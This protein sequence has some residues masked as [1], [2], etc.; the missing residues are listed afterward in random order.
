MKIA[1][2]LFVIL[3]LTAVNG[4][5]F[6]F[7]PAEVGHAQQTFIE[8]VSKPVAYGY[9]VRTS[10][11]DALPISLSED[12]V[13]GG[14]GYKVK[15][16]TPIFVQNTVAAH[17]TPFV[18]S[19]EETSADSKDATSGRFGYSYHA[20]APVAVAAAP[21]YHHS[22][23]AAPVAVEVKDA[24]VNAEEISQKSGAFSYSVQAE[25]PIFVPAPVAVAYG[26]KIAKSGEEAVSDK[27]SGS[28]SYSYQAEAP[29]VA[30]AVPVAVGYSDAVHVQ[31]PLVAAYE[32]TV[33]K[34][35]EAAEEGKGS[36]A[37]SY[38]AEAPIAAAV[39]VAHH[40][41]VEAP[42]ASVSWTNVPVSH[43]RTAVESSEV[44]AEGKPSSAFSYSYSAEAPVVSAVP[45]AHH[46]VYAAP[47][48]VEYKDSAE[49]SE[50]VG[51]SGAFAY[52]VH[53]E[54]PVVA[55]VPVAY[56]QVPVSY[57][58]TVVKTEDVDAGVKPSKAFAYSYTAEAPVAAPVPVAHAVVAAPVAVEY[59]DS[60]ENVGHTGSFAYSVHAEAP[61][62]F[63]ADVAA[64]ITTTI[65]QTVVK[66]EDAG[67]EG[68]PS[69]AFAYSYT[70]EA[71]V[72]AP[73][74]QPAVVAAP[75][76]VEYKD[77]G[78]KIEAVSGN[79]GAFA[80]SVHAE[81]PVVAPV[82]VS[83]AHVPVSHEHTV[84]KSTEVVAEE[85][86]SKAFAY[87]YTAEAP[88]SV[89][90]AHHAVVAAP[91]AVEH[92]DYVEHSEAAGPSGAFAYSVHA[93]APVVAPVPVAYSQVPVS[94]EHT[95]VKTEQVDAG[96]QPSKAFAYSYSAEAPV[97]A[98]VPVA[99]H[100]VV[101]AP[102][103]VEYKDAVEQGEGVSGIKS[104]AFSYSVH[105]EAPVVAPVPVAYSQVPVSYEQ[106]VV[107]SD[108]GAAAAEGKTSGS[109]AYSY[110]AEAP[111][112]VP[113]A[114][115]AVVPAHVAVEFKDAGERVEAYHGAYVAAAP[116]GVA[117][118][119]ALYN[120]GD[121][122]AEG[123]SSG[124]FGYTYHAEA[125][126]AAAP[127]AHHQVVAAAPVAL[128]YEAVDHGNVAIAG[129]SAAFG[130][131][132]HA[133]TPAAHPTYVHQSGVAYSVVPTGQAVSTQVA[134][135]DASYGYYV[136]GGVP[137]AELQQEDAVSTQ[138]VTFNTH[139][140]HPVFGVK[141]IS[142]H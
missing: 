128:A 85:K 68:K 105:A 8:D 135:D 10:S 55:S 20:A 39:P 35:G 44:S 25:A 51:Q 134:S 28:F 62:V 3:A 84:V 116:V 108:D 17:A 49:K 89:P 115:H 67:V 33:V 140:Y 113:V 70:A 1:V 42:V 103:A 18:V 4:A 65:E 7:I 16:A 31:S 88:I 22:V 94:Y 46:A 130:Y 32:Q 106:T 63:H 72:A 139:G 15:A 112:A 138:E 83:Y 100:A 76:S 97:A 9:R 12:H 37:Y 98:P 71:P 57:E 34:S 41:V 104:G 5:P 19:H 99:H 133:E 90:V 52:S 75:I 126:V 43:E 102:V 54:A 61:A 110:S 56:S 131:S 122:I 27:S 111:V 117:Y 24:A 79:S 30:A 60:L 114:H 47:V 121:K 66:T 137:V 2:S 120:Y 36:F 11:V 21:V 77:Y 6:G 109:F 48:A 53:A 92:K 14:F 86:P 125:P 119:H 87:S 69:G 64:P 45:V 78:E 40:A 50:A 96:V 80:Y 58:H 74:F 59:K 141:T 13:T 93:E 91:V 118:E 142:H 101:A 123:K 38:S 107:K 95:V 73:E 81:A 127:V 29:V 129:R 82:A 132:V 23:V 136:Q 124:S 26:E